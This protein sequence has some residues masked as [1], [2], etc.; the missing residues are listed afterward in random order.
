MWRNGRAYVILLVLLCVGVLWFHGRVADHHLPYLQYSNEASNI[1]QAGVVANMGP[2]PVSLQR[3]TLPVYLLAIVDW[4]MLQTGQLT[5]V[6]EGDNLPFP[7]MWDLGMAVAELAP[8]V[9]TVNRMVCA[10]MGAGTVFLVFIL[11][12][13]LFGEPRT[14]FIAAVFASVSGVIAKGSII[15]RPEIFMCFFVTL[16]LIGAARV[17]KRGRCRDYLWAGLF[18][19]LAC[20]SKYNAGL[21]VL[22]FIAAHFLPGSRAGRPHRWM[23]WGLWLCVLGFLAGTPYAA[24]DI[25]RFLAD[26]GFEL[27]H[28]RTG[29]LGRDGESEWAYLGVIL[30][31]D[32]WVAW[33]ALIGVLRG[34]VTRSRPILLL[35][36]FGLPYLVAISLLPVQMDRHVTP[37]LPVIAICAAAEC[38]VVLNWTLRRAKVS[39]IWPWGVAT[40]SVLGGVI[41]VVWTGLQQSIHLVD[42]LTGENGRDQARE[43]IEE[44]I[45]KGAVIAVESRTPWIDRHEYEVRRIPVSYSTSALWVHNP[46]WYAEH[47]F[48]YLVTSSRVQGLYRQDPYRYSDQIAAYR[49]LN[50][51]NEVVGIFQGRGWK[52]AVVRVS[53]TLRPDPPPPPPPWFLWAGSKEPQPMLPGEAWPVVVW[54]GPRIPPINSLVGLSRVGS[55]VS[56]WLERGKR[57]GQFEP[58]KDYEK[59]RIKEGQPE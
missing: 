39:G 13:E 3:P 35:L 29:H 19:G 26:L 11:T 18:T 49:R 2:N 9:V 47:G 15:V 37:L 7:K 41:F 45:P 5:G 59:R 33:L 40:G 36:V 51:A 1:S 24:L 6:Y 48:E 42:L 57:S 23:V 56:E 25:D 10:L 53:E 34:M 38:A 52:I 8:E 12:R 55:F 16:A 54:P 22:S 14:A 50:I 46:R 21:V 44:N 32:G 17:L 31:K 30:A 43:W 28:Y 4:T 20:S 58:F 27:A